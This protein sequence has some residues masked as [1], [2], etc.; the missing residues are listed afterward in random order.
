MVVSGKVQGVGFRAYAAQVA[1]RL[2]MD[3]EVWNRP[4]GRV[5]A[6]VSGDEMRLR[7][8]VDALRLGPG[9]VSSVDARLAEAAVEPGFRIRPTR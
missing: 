8:F 2:E 9:T 5:E 6:V 3:G 1:K 4:D 7:E